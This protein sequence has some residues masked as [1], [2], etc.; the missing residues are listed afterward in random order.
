MNKA[1]P[2]EL[3]KSL[4]IVDVLKNA[5]IDFVPVIV[6]SEQ[7]RNELI[8][9]LLND[10]EAL[11]SDKET[12]KPCLPNKGRCKHWDCGW[13]YSDKEGTNAKSGA[14]LNPAECN[15]FEVL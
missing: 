7:H 11:S 2:V 12:D 9:S 15:L 14:C 1:T 3:R 5:G 8:K 6:K 10:L 13:C 4:Q